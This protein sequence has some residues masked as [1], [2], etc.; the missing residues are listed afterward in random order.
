[1]EKNTM[2]NQTRPHYVTNEMYNRLQA[3]MDSDASVGAI[4]ETVCYEFP[5]LDRRQAGLAAM[6]ASREFAKVAQ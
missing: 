3:M 2:S 4:A 5:E 6:W 1:M